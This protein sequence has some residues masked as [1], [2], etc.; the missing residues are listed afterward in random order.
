VSTRARE[1]VFEAMWSC[2][3]RSDDVAEPEAFRL[4]DV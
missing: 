1:R 3:V 2:A 4:G